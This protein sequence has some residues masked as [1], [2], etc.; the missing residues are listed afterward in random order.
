[1]FYSIL[2]NRN[3]ESLELMKQCEKNFM[4]GFEHSI[5]NNDYKNNI[6][7]RV[8]F[9]KKFNVNNSYFKFI[10]SVLSN[11][12]IDYLKNLSKK[13]KC[14]SGQEKVSLCRVLKS[15]QRQLHNAFYIYFYYTILVHTADFSAQCFI[16][17]Y[18]Y[19]YDN[20]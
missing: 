17:L 6:I 13:V 11:K 7:T 3:Y 16:D 15:K 14:V 10:K 18:D 19:I 9:C 8:E 5:K 4:L 12:N 2:L 20:E 1:M